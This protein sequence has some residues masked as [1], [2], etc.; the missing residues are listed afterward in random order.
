MWLK[1][2]LVTAALLAP[3][4]PALAAQPVRA[5]APKTAAPQVLG[6]FSV[7]PRHCGWRQGRQSCRGDP[8][9]AVPAKPLRLPGRSTRSCVLGSTP[10]SDELTRPDA[11]RKW[12]L[13]P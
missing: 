10:E 7:T 3:G 11:I 4:L 13:R 6:N 1:L 2:G 5:A 9:N 8:A 12:P